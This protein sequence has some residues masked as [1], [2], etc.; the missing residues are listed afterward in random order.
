MDQEELSGEEAAHELRKLA[1]VV[2]AN[3]DRLAMA[4]GC[5]R[6]ASGDPGVDL[7]QLVDVL[8]ARA[9]PIEAEMPTLGR[10]SNRR[11]RSEDEP[12]VREVEPEEA[13]APRPA[14]RPRQASRL[15][16]PWF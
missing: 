3:L 2:E 12:P 5:G 11:S 15:A 16:G 14:S 10:A 8:V 13:P 4:Y 6:P 1:A 7:D 9:Q